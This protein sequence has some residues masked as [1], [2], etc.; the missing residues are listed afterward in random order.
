MN[1]FG[2]YKNYAKV[3][4]VKILPKWQDWQCVMLFHVDFG[5]KIKKKYILFPICLHMW[6]LFCKFAPKFVVRMCESAYTRENESVIK[7]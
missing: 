3:L 7:R 2:I 6:E 5:D 4:I 1:Q